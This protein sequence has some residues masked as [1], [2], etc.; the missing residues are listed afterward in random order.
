[1]F[2]RKGLLF[3][4]LFGL[5]IYTGE[6]TAGSNENAVLS[7][8]LIADGG[9][10]NQ[11]DDGVTSGT[12]SGQGTKIAVEVFAKGVTTPLLGVRIVF[13]FD[14]SVLTYV[15]ARNSVFLFSIPHE[16]IGTNFAP[17]ES[18]TLSPSGFLARAEFTTAVDVTG[19]EFSI[20]I[21]RVILA[22]SRTSS[23]SLTTT[24]E[25]AFNAASS[26]DTPPSPDFDGDGVVGVPDF[27]L[28]LDHFGSSRSDGTYRPKYDLD[29]NGVIGVSDFLIFVD[30]FGKEVPP[31]DRGGSEEMVSILDANLRAVVEDSLGKARGAPITRGE[32]VTLTRLEAPNANI[33]D[34]TGLEFATGL[35]S[36][37][38]GPQ[39]SSNSNSISDLSPL[40]GLT[41]LRS[42]KL[43]HNTISDLSPLSGLTSLTVL[44]LSGNTITDLSPLSN[45]T[46]LTV[47]ELSDNSIVDLSPLS[48]LTN[49]TTLNLVFNSVVDIS[50]LSGLTNLTTLNLVF[51]SVVDISPLSGLT[52][53]T[54]L[55]L[56]GNTITDISPL[57]G[58]TNLTVVGLQN[59]SV[60]DISPLSGLTNL[61]TLYLENILS[62]SL[63]PGLV[64]SNNSVVDISPLIGL[65]NLTELRLQ[66]NS[67]SDLSPLVANTGLGSGDRVDVRNNPLSATSINTHIPTLH[68]R[69]VAVLFTFDD[70]TPVSIPD[71][72][73][74]AEIEDALDKSSGETIT[75]EDMSNLTRVSAGS[76]NIS[77]LTG[78]EFATNLL[79]LYLYNNTISDVSALSGL[80]NLTS[81]T[82]R[83]NSITDIS[84]LSGLTN[85]SLLRLEEN[86]ISDV[87]A[88]SGLTSLERLRLQNNTIS[89]ISALSGLTN[90]TGLTLYRNSISDLSPLV[91]N[92]GLGSGDEVDVRDN[93]LSDTSINTH[94]PALQGRGV[95]VRF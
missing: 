32:M 90:L 76:A 66:N 94:I 39:G 86:S 1:M 49:L 41:N 40:E 4:A 21:K 44:E 13:D 18:V 65:T 68:S 77:D 27:L 20:G 42:L 53:L 52:S 26:S 3:F 84:P 50:P 8:D 23:D 56:S 15:G 92:M 87:S 57:S 70:P 33:S 46:S 7:L 59:N 28:F 5:L 17:S 89:D 22:E 9:A 74:R 31:S 48:G 14:A 47:L 16:V 30:N 37:N 60:V 55:F 83:K 34:L 10:D 75:R 62:T 19:R 79:S 45:L 80:T 25:I 61:T 6:A 51:N 24:E 91:A 2:L 88:L 12:V 38:F 71:A 82:L 93:P 67:I 54:T 72:N 29:G 63:I 11:I 85:L 69:G 58:L 36:L 35:T 43:Q 64:L 73:L 95:T 81:L 78:L